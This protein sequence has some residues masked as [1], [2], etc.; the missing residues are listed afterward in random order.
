MQ[1]GFGIMLSGEWQKRDN[2]KSM[3]SF[4]MDRWDLQVIDLV[5]IF[6]SEAAVHDAIEEDNIDISTVNQLGE[7]FNVDPDLVV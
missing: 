4:L 1:Q 7:L 5:T 3:L 2:P 6:G